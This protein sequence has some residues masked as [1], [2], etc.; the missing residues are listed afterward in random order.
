M[1]LETSGVL[2]VTLGMREP[3]PLVISWTR[4][5]AS[6]PRTSPRTLAVHMP[7]AEQ[8]VMLRGTVT[9]ISGG[10]S[11]GATLATQA[12]ESTIRDDLPL[13]QSWLAFL[14]AYFGEPSRALRWSNIGAIEH[15]YGSGAASPGA[16]VTTAT[17]GTGSTTIN[18]TVTRRTWRLD[19]SGF[20]T[21]YDTDRIVPD[22]EA[23][24]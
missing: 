22:I 23:I 12:S 18:A 8:W 3:D 1:V 10:G 13:M 14:R 20:G 21:S 15:S 24:R 17:L 16:L 11:E 4:A 19:E 2:V 5:S 6:W 9:G 7:N